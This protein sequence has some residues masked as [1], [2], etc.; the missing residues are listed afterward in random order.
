MAFVLLRPIMAQQQTTLSLDVRKEPQMTSMDGRLEDVLK[1]LD[2]RV[3]KL[4]SLLEATWP[5]SGCRTV[6]ERLEELEAAE[7]AHPPPGMLC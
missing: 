7:R 2:E 4:S 6:Q 5:G 1:A 3:G